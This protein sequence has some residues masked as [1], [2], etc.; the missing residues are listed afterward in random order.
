MDQTEPTTHAA[1]IT[2]AGGFLRY[3]ACFGIFVALC[4]AVAFGKDDTL[5]SLGLMAY[6]ACGIYLNRVVLRRLVE[7][8]PMY[9]TLGNVTSGKLWFFAA[10]PFMYALLFFKLSIDKVL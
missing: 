1:Q 5:T 8:H 9:N 10:W 7:W 4:F 6:L 2:L 3:L